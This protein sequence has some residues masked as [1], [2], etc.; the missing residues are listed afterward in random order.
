MRRSRVFQRKHRGYE[1][2]GPLKKLKGTQLEVDWYIEC[3]AA[4]GR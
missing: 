1:L 2:H 3:E 4:N